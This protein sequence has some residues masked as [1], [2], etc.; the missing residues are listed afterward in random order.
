MDS[1]GQLTELIAQHQLKPVAVALTHGHVD[2]MFSVYPVAAGYDIPALIH[3]ADRHLLTDPAAALSPEGR[4]FISQLGGTFAEPDRVEE[5]VDGMRSQIAGLEFSVTH[6]PGHTPGS[7]VFEISTSADARLV[8]GDVLFRGSIGRTDLPG[9]DHHQMLKSLERVVMSA[10]DDMTVHC[11]HGADTTIG[12][13]KRSN[14]YIRG[15]GL[16]SG[17]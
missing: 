3:P 16:R 11:G 10:P 9:G 7:V 12:D 17:L 1:V 13:E 4:T 6:A 15:L 14:P 2:H 5:A 8:S